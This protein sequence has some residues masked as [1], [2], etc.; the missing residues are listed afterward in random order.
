MRRRS[1]SSSG[2]SAKS[3]GLRI[4]GLWYPGVKHEGIG[5]WIFN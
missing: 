5:V 2:E 1:I 3:M 4:E